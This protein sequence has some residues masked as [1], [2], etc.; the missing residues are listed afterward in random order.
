M[1]LNIWSKLRVHLTWS[2]WR[3]PALRLLMIYLYICYL[4]ICAANRLG[5]AGRRH[6]FVMCYQDFDWSVRELAADDQRGEIRGNW[7]WHRV[8]AHSDSAAS[9]GRKTNVNDH[10]AHTREPNSCARNR[11]VNGKKLS[12]SGNAESEAQDCTL[13]DR[14]VARH[15]L[16]APDTG[17]VRA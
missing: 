4:C 7:S 5:F 6:V 2:N 8:C 1:F 17:E 10:C 12:R 15:L 9:H 3:V 14:T 13:G 11:N 16:D